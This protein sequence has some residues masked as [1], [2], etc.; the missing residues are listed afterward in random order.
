VPGS[1]QPLI[2]NRSL[3]MKAEMFVGHHEARQALV[4]AVAGVAT[5]VLVANLILMILY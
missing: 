5:I 4:L 3:A 1:R 2:F